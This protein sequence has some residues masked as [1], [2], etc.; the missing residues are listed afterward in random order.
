MHFSRNIQFWAFIF[1]AI[2]AFFLIFYSTLMPF[3]IGLIIAY[4]LNPAVDYLEDKGIGRILSTN[5]VIIGFMMAIIVFFLLFI[6]IISDQ[7]AIFVNN[8]PAYQHKAIG[9]I[10]QFLGISWQSDL[11]N[12]HIDYEKYLHDYAQGALG[13]TGN[14]ITQ[15]FT[16]IIALFKNLTFL[17]IIPI[18]AFYFLMDWHILTAKIDSWLPRQ[19][20]LTIRDL[21]NEMDELQ[22]GFIRGQVLVC[23]IQA[24]FYILALNVINIDY[25][26]T[27]GFLTGVMTFIPYI[28][29]GLGFILV[30]MVSF[31][32]YLPDYMP[33]IWVCVV[34]AIGQT[35]EGYVWI[36]KI[37]GGSVSLHPLW[38]M[39]S[40]LAFGSI[41][42]LSGMLIAVPVTAAIGVLTRFSLEKYIQSPYY[43]KNNSI[44]T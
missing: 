38:V 31:V 15:I 40:L 8:L 5:I 20:A 12:T 35:L 25:A 44:E 9:Y 18:V 42:G 19:Y 37:V 30:A 21:M 41:W 22:S 6:P 32:Q 16:N 24:A 34:F 33:F 43:Y 14:V 23:V 27:L 36:P 26:T 28:G 3:L 11:L 29:A 13:V 2:C 4:I 1:L 17:I 7:I 39:F 10:N